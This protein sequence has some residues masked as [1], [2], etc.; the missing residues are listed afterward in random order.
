VSNLAKKEFGKK[1]KKVRIC[2]ESLAKNERKFG[3]FFST[4]SQLSVCVICVSP[5]VRANANP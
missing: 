1:G 3:K 5:K 4:L 2:Q